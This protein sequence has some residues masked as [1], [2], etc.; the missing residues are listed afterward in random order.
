MWEYI[1]GIW[2]ECFSHTWLPC[3]RADLIY[4]K[5]WPQAVS[6]VC[7]LGEESGGAA[8]SCGLHAMRFLPD[9]P[10]SRRE[11]ISKGYERL[12][13]FNFVFIKVYRN[14]FSPIVPL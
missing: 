8:A 7:S 13:H 11:L 6:S 2:R 14:F 9:R 12:N 10:A 5:I 4:F 3:V 1:M